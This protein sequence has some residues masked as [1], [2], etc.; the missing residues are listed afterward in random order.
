MK[1]R[2]VALALSLL[3]ITP[4]I[5]GAG[6]SSSGQRPAAVDQMLA[7]DMIQVAQQNLKA[8]GFNPGHVDGIF[9]AQTEAAVL[10]YQAK[11]GLP[12]TGLLDEITRNALLP[13]LSG[14]EG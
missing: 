4:V 14:E 9:D 12:Q 10:A 1:T 2:F 6:G 8:A 11:Y 7:A 13:G 5:V 3:L